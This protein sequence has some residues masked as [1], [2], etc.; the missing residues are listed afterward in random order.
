[1]TAISWSP[2]PLS[3]VSVITAAQAT[4][5]VILD[6][7]AD[8]W[9]LMW[10]LRRL[11]VWRE[12]VAWRWRWLWRGGTLLD[13]ER[14]RSRVERV[15]GEIGG[16]CWSRLAEKID[17]GADELED[18]AMASPRRAGQLAGDIIRRDDVW[19]VHMY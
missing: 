3:P 8:M 16:R 1:M 10:C 2:I 13:A 4:L 11:T 7:R 12:I 18:T 19:S 17:A 9:C 6:S 15:P 5:A 14:I